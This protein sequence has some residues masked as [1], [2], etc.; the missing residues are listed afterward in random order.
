MGAYVMRN[1]P[2]SVTNYDTDPVLQSVGPYST[3]Y[4]HRKYI[5]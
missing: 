2:L 5:T 4:G 1:E 3:R